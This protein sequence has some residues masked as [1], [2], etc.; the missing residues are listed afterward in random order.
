MRVL[1]FLYLPFQFY[2]ICA[3]PAHVSLLYSRHMQ[4][5]LWIKYFLSSNVTA[6]ANIYIFVGFEVLTAVVMKNFIFWY[7]TQC[8]PLKVNWR[9]RGTYRLHLQGQRISKAWPVLWPWRWRRHIPPKFRLTLNGL[10]GIIFQKIELFIY[11]FVPL[12]QVKY[13][14]TCLMWL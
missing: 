8:S 7:I 10:H 2:F 13:I 4:F 3:S 1:V 9:I 5:L 11:I 12:V 14:V 6:F